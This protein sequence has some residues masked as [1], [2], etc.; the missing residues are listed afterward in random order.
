MRDVV[1][2][3]EPA[4]R[5]RDVARIV[6]V[7]D[8]DVMLGQERTH[9]RAQERREMAR[10]R[11]D[12]EDARLCRVDVLAEPQQ[13]GERRGV[14]GLFEHRDLAVSHRHGIDAEG[15]PGVREA[16]ARDQLIGGAEVAQGGV[17]RC[18]VQW[19]R[20]P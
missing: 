14:G 4:V 20:P 12:Q 16:R 17:V 1:V 10:E 3:A 6:P 9:R 7:G 8:V 13:R 5:E 2:E 11:R 15:R 18:A 19:P